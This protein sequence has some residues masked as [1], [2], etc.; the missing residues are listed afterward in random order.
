GDDHPN[1]AAYRHDSPIFR[2]TGYM[3]ILPLVFRE[4]AMALRGGGN[5]DA[6]YRGD[7]VVF[8]ADLSVRL[9]AAA[10][11]AAA[12]LG[13]SIEQQLAHAPAA[14]PPE[15]PASNGECAAPWST[16]CGSIVG[17]VDYL[18]A[19]QR[20]ALIVGQPMMTATTSHDRQASQ[21]NALAA[22]IAQRYGRR[23]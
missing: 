23:A 5:L 17:A 12:S 6:Q 10:L 14:P 3:P 20:K 4:K 11:N 15:A 7:K 19:H 21:H 18:L 1:L 9:G 2:L 8:T 13:D 16:Y 22:M